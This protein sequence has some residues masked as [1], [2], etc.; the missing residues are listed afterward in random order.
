MCRDSGRVT[1]ADTV[2]HIKAHKGDTA[3]FFAF[4][5]TASLCAHHHNSAKQSEERLGYMK[6][7]DAHGRPLDVN[8][9]WGK[10]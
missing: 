8:H 3:L 5:N 10:R 1:A 6:G 7:C 9:P 4:D 2:D